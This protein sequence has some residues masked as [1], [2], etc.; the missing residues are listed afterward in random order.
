MQRYFV[1]GDQWQADQIIISEQDAH[2]LQRV[3]R[4]RIGDKVICSDGLARE[5]LAEVVA[6]GADVHLRVYE[7][8][9]MDREPQTDIWV[10]QA[11]PKGDKFETVLQKGTELGAARFVPF[12]SQRTVVQYD[13]KKVVKVHVRWQ[14]IVKEAAEQ[15]HRNR[16]PQVTEPILWKQLL[17]L[18]SEVDLALVC[19]EKATAVSI[20]QALRRFEDERVDRGANEVRRILVVI[21]PEGG[22]SEAEIDA[23]EAAGMQVVT[24]GRRILRTETAALVALTCAFYQFGDLE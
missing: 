24:L 21:G 23:A 22:L 9:P 19:Y 6:I 1:D 7:W 18:V 2:H 12:V 16:I 14:K 13:A 11:L 17:A 10:A 5:A 8:L 3:M 15:A 20:G 4:A